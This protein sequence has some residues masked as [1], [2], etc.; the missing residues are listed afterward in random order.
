MAKRGHN[1]T[2]LHRSNFDE[3]E[4]AAAMSPE[5]A[6]DL[7][8]GAGD[9]VPNICEDLYGFNHFSQQGRARP[10]GGKMARGFQWI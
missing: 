10:H 9:L 5:E 6:S 4:S 8:D 3:Q 7:A 2:K 1:M